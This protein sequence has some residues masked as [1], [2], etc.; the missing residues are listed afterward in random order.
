MA[1]RTKRQDNILS[2]VQF[3]LDLSCT[4]DD[5]IIVTEAITLLTYG[6][7]KIAKRCPHKETRIMMLEEGPRG[8]RC[9]IFLLSCLLYA[10]ISIEQ[11]YKVLGQRRKQM[12]IIFMNIV[13]NESKM[14]ET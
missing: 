4:F 10:K 12:K 2:F 5:G 7:A 6:H 8:A 9:R 1:S 14:A 3:G 13:D 11:V